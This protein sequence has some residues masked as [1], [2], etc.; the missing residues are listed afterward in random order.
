[1]FGR[2]E[3]QA[4]DD[5]AQGLRHLERMS[6]K[7]EFKL[8]LQTMVTLVALTVGAVYAFARIE[9]SLV[10]INTRVATIEENRFSSSTWNKE[11]SI[12]DA[13]FRSLDQG[14]Q[15]LCQELTHFAN[16]QNEA[17]I[18]LQCPVTIRQDGRLSPRP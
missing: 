9:L 11:R 12:I 7:G 13:E 8:E 16:Q 4:K 14:L 6:R 5:V 10:G 15:R 18:S 1:M 2:Y 3:K 17:K